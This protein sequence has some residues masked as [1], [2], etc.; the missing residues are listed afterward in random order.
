[1][2]HSAEGLGNQQATAASRAGRAARRPA[3]AEGRE[4]Y[5]VLHPTDATADVWTPDYMLAQGIYDEF[6]Q[7]HGQAHLHLETLPA[8]QYD[9]ECLLRGRRIGA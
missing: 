1:M 2:T 8:G 6:V 3:V 9:A 7:K 5:H 4:L